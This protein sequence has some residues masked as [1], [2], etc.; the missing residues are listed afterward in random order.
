MKETNLPTLFEAISCQINSELGIA[1]AHSVHAPT[2]GDVAQKMWIKVLQSYLPTRYCVDTGFVI[3]SK[4]NTS[5]QIDIVIYDRQ[6]SPLIF[7]IQGSHYFPAESIYCVIEVKTNVTQ[8]EYQYA[9]KKATSVRRLFR[10]SIPIPHAGGF[11]DPKP[12]GPILSGLVGHTCVWVDKLDEHLSNL[13][14]ARNSTISLPEGQ[15]DVGC[16]ASIA[17]FLWQS[18]SNCFKLYRTSPATNFVFELLARLQELATVPMLDI[19][20]YTKWIC[21]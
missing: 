15:L 14:Q 3:D 5:E 12:P 21:D 11:Y 2:K 17:A 18:Q 8:A 10:T 1:K 7:T 19:R 4:G 16:I 13:N 9:Q 6:Y 20:A